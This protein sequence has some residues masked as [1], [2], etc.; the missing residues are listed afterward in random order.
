M[1]KQTI[2]IGTSANDRS[3]TKNRDGWD[4]CNDNF[5]EL[6]NITSGTGTIVHGDT[7]PSV[8]GYRTFLFDG[9]SSTTI[10]TLDDATPGVL[11]I[12]IG[13]SDTEVLGI[14]NGGSFSLESSARE[15]SE[16]Y[17]LVLLCISTSLFI[18]IKYAEP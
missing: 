8:A 7:T 18:E 14:N 13:T 2:N 16:N 4:I 11:Y 12:L 15:L 17:V 6:Y 9:V 3:G 1:A 10:T 5:G